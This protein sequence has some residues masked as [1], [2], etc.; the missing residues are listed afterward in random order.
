ME[1][2][3]KIRL[4]KTLRLEN[5]SLMSRGHTHSLFIMDNVFRYQ[6]KKEGFLCLFVDFEDKYLTFFT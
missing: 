6:V 5:G 3:D 2:L 4:L 1:H